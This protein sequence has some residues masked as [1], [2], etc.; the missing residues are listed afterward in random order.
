L[1]SRKLAIYLVENLHAAHTLRGIVFNIDEGGK[2]RVV[3]TEF[4]PKRNSSRRY[5]R[6]GYQPGN[7]SAEHAEQCIDEGWRTAYER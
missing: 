4:S 3:V 6:L 5:T 7:S 1:G 2:T